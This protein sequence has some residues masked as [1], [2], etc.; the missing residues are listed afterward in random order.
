M[1]YY[2][3]YVKN[4]PKFG[5]ITLN[6]LCS[7]VPPEEREP[8]KMEKVYCARLTGCSM[9]NSGLKGTGGNGRDCVPFIRALDLRVFSPSSKSR[10]DHWRNFIVFGRPEGHCKKSQRFAS[11]E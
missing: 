5:S 3:S 4:S 2:K 6:S 7:V 1:D 10:S 9:V 11:C 8:G